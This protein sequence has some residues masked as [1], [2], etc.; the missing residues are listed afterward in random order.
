MEQK[1]LLSKKEIIQVIGSPGIVQRLILC[2]WLKPIRPIK[3][4][5]R[6]LFTRQNLH[7]VCERMDNGEELPMLPSEK[8]MK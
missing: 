5:Q 1:R 6:A 7:T 8:Q 3:P 2:G 4:G